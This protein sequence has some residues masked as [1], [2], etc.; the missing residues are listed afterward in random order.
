[1]VATAWRRRGGGG[2]AV[3]TLSAT[4]ATAWRQI[5]VHN[6]AVTTSVK[7]DEGKHLWR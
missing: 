4:A 7:E 5:A 2:S 1:L 3:A 6:D